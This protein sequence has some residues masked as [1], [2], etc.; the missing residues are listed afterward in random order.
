MNIV[1]K[2][3]LGKHPKAA[4][5]YSLV[6]AKNILFATDGSYI[7]NEEDIKNNNIIKNYLDEFYSKDVV[8]S[9]VHV[10][11][12]NTELVI[13]VSNS[14]PNLN[15]KR[16][17]NIFRYREDNNF[18]IS[19]I[20]CAYGDINNKGIDYNGGEFSSDFTYNVNNHL[21]V[22][23]CEYG[24]NHDNSPLKT[25]NLGKFGVIS[26]LDN[27]DR[28]LNE[29]LLP[30]VPEIILPFVDNVN[31][32][33]G[34]CYKGWY[35]IFIRFKI[36]N[37][38][39]TQWYNIGQPIYVDTINKKQII[40][41]P[42]N[43]SS[44][45]YTGIVFYDQTY[46]GILEG[47]NDKTGFVVGCTD[48]FSDESDIA[49]ETFS[50]DLHIR[51]NNYNKFQLGF[52]CATK[53][54]SKCFR[55]ND[56]SLNNFNIFGQDNTINFVYNHNI[57]SEITVDELT[58]TYNNYY[59]VK[60][61]HNYKNK[62]YI[63]NYIEKNL[64]NSLIQPLIKNITPKLHVDK[65][66]DLGILY[67][68][69]LY[70][71]KNP[72]PS[73]YDSSFGN[74]INLTEFLNVTPNTKVNIKSD[75]GNKIIKARYVVLKPI[76]TD[77]GFIY[78][79]INDNG[80]I[81]EIGKIKPQKVTIEVI[82]TEQKVT[83]MT[84]DT[85]FIKGCIYGNPE[86]NF[87]ERK[88]NSTLIPGE[89]YNFFIHFVDK[90]GI[91][92]NG[93]RINNNLKWT[94]ENS[95]KEIYP[96][97]F[98]AN[99][100]YKYAAFPLNRDI[101]KLENDKYVLNLDDINFY[102]AIDAETMTLK[103]LNNSVD[104]VEYFKSFYINFE[105]ERYKNYKWYQIVNIPVEN[106]GVFINNNNEKLFKVPVLDNYIVDTCSSDVTTFCNRINLDLMKVQFDN[107]EL[108]EGY[109]GYFIS[110]E[111]HEPIKRMTGVLFKDDFLSQTYIRYNKPIFYVDYNNNPSYLSVNIDQS[112][113]RSNNN[114]RNSGFMNFYSQD[115]DIKD[116]LK[117]EFDI[118][119]IEAANLKQEDIA[120]YQY[121]QKNNSIEFC[122]DYNKPQ[123]DGNDSREIKSYPI[124]DYKLCVGGA[125]SDNRLGKGS[126]MSFKNSYNLFDSYTVT[127]SEHKFAKQYKVTLFNCN[128]NIYM[129]QNKTLIRITDVYY[130]NTEISSTDVIKDG[131][132]GR[133]SFNGVLV[134]EQNGMF[135][136]G[137]EYA[138][139]GLKNNRPYYPLWFIPGTF[140]SFE[141][142]IP[143]A[144]YVQYLDC[145]NIIAES[146][147]INNYPK[148]LFFPYNYKDE[149]APEDDFQ[150]IYQGVIVTGK[151]SIDLFKEP[152]TSIDESFPKYL[153][154]YNSNIVYETNFNK[155]IR[156]SNI[157]ADESKENNW[158]K[159]SYNDYKNIIENKGIITNV[160]SLGTYLLI[161]TEHSLFLFDVDNVLRTNNK[162]VQLANQEVF[163]V[164][165]KEI[166]TSKLGYGGLQN[167]HSWIVGN[168]GYIFYDDNSNK[169]YRFDNGSL[170]EIDNNIK[171]FIKERLP[172]NVVFGHDIKNNRLLISM[173][174]C[175][176]KIC[177]PCTLSYNYI[178]NEFISFHD[179]WFNRYYN[180]KQNLYLFKDYIKEFYIENNHMGLT[181]NNN[182]ESKFSIIVNSD[183]DV[184]KYLEYIDYKIKKLANSTSTDVIYSPVPK[185][186]K[187]FSGNKLRIY[188]DL[189][190][191]GEIDISTTN[192]N[193]NL[194]NNTEKPTFDLG[195]WNFSY[196][197]N[198]INTYNG[199]NASSLSR[200]YG[201]YFII[202]FTVLNNDTKRWIF[203]TL[204]VFNTIHER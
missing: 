91:A 136:K 119:Q 187:P 174:L 194:F 116:N 110:Y 44:K 81:I 17:I 20:Y 33:K 108:P 120:P 148:S 198:K 193:F 68:N 157:I 192:I 155:T 163:D 131:Y 118:M 149:S 111:K 14:R 84:N 138:P 201:N 134:Y 85:I 171:D 83:F 16:K 107:I 139:T 77:I 165:Y 146:K 54:Y 191:T 117:L 32:V 145:S 63:A 24:N 56:F 147:Q 178:F 190:D 31:Y 135:L 156:S 2:L 195:K 49:N 124:P 29:N 5:N 204:N 160:I 102:E 101:L 18:N 11:P 188:N 105:Q 114:N 64:N 140:L 42:Y 127:S 196:F 166:F 3:Q 183:F 123:L 50:F 200:L 82:N 72:S 73:Q 80:N 62:L 103:R 184:I 43:R 7:T 170:I 202:E 128:R 45:K 154:N 57:V 143:F 176:N 22:S 30:I 98:K 203:E 181:S 93:Y 61:I 132:N 69:Y 4:D 52:I 87:K 197:R 59:N 9:I 78:I 8:Y 25:I 70:N 19:E 55:T 106:F 158:R 167:R 66:K 28:Y 41:Y 175:L 23:F 79:E 39:Y 21:I 6:D 96:V 86:I 161:H 40:K 97:Y 130:P 74:E 113:V 75:F 51:D 141:N 186:I 34:K 125:A 37:I 36:N 151:N 95:I 100:V 153:T 92:T 180:T 15:N 179:Y 76:N 104:N 150:V 10:L 189:I 152:Q 48:S 129:N 133:Y 159:F 185:E 60:T 144:A 177:I 173:I 71:S 142:D 12:C 126:C 172:N 112:V 47:Y 94:E 35:Y 1:P 199:E 137:D 58:T 65:I 182:S 121:Y 169:F 46:F 168:F 26:G 122:Y 90:Y 115:L 53:K 67:N 164:N 162:N 89:V 13:F 27:G 88:L 38:D 99:N 109:V